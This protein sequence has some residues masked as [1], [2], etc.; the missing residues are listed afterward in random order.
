KGISTLYSDYNIDGTTDYRQKTNY[1]LGS[2]SPAA[3]ASQDFDLMA[4]MFRRL[5]ISWSGTK[6]YLNSE[7][8][9]YFDGWFRL[10]GLLVLSGNYY[11]PA[12]LPTQPSLK[13]Y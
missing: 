9:N 1:L 5:V 10:L 12:S 6:G 11:D 3:L 8:L 13:I 2:S 7:P 4:K